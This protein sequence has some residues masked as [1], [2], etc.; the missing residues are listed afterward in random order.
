MT[1]TVKEL[2]IEL[3]TCDM[4][5]EAV[6]AT[7]HNVASIAYIAENSA[8]FPHRTILEAGLNR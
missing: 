8:K 7:E 5:D 3:L 1:M 2:I 4:D 6:I